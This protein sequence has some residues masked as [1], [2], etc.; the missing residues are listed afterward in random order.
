MTTFSNWTFSV[1]GEIGLTGS[2]GPT[3]PTGP[4]GP[5]GPTGPQ[6]T[7][8]VRD[9]YSN[10]TLA[11]TDNNKIIKV[12][13]DPNTAAVTITIPSG[14]FSVGHQITILRL[15]A[16]YNVIIAGAA[17]VTLYYTP[18]TYLRTLGSAATILCT[19]TNEFFL[20]GDLVA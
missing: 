16:S 9:V 1:A 13:G 7:I 4:S 19:G 6:P 5:T 15:S 3:G 11:V 14:I 2:T 17:G 8:T 10:E 12:N 18:G 20:I